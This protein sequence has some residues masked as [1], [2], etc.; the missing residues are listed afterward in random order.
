MD[1]TILAEG[2][3]NEFHATGETFTGT[4]EEVQA[5]LE[6]L[7]AETGICHSAELAAP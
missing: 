3:P 1:W 2:P 5:H 4:T 6:Q 7:R